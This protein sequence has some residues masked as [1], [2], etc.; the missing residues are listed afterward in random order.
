[1]PNGAKHWVFTL[2]NYVDEEVRALSELHGNGFVDYLI[3]GKETGDNGT[4][5]LQGYVSFS[6]RHTL[7]QAKHRIGARAHLE[8]KRGTPEQASN[9]CKKD[10][11]FTEFGSLPA[12]SGKR[13]DWELLLNWVKDLDGRPREKDLWDAFPSLYGRYRDSIRRMIDVYHPALPRVQ[14]DLREWQSALVTSLR[15]P[16]DDRR[17][18]FVVDP[19]GAGG[20]TWLVKYVMREFESV[21]VLKIGKRDDLA[22]TVDERNLIFLLDVPRNSLQHLQYSVLEMLKDQMVFSPKYDSCMKVMEQVPHVVVFT[23]ETPD[24]NALTHDRYQI[25]NISEPN[26]LT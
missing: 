11:D 1:M 15:A 21:Q 3:F 18:Q 25:T 16:P 7:A 12:G 19:I 9:Y 23:N 5:H 22:Y 14:G 17:V 20:K 13:T 24:M 8:Q 10:G 26:I 6:Q 2:N 4:P